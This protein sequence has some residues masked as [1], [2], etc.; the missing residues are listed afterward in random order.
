VYE[1]FPAHDVLSSLLILRNT[2]KNRGGR[3][4]P[5]FCVVVSVCAVTHFVSRAHFCGRAGRQNDPRNVRSLSREG[6]TSC[7]TVRVQFFL[8]TATTA[9][10]L[11]ITAAGAGAQESFADI[12]HLLRPG[13]TVFVTDDTGTETR[14]RV[15]D[16]GPSSL[17]V[18]INGTERDWPAPTVQR[19]E[20]RGDSVRN[21]AIAGSVTAGIFGLLGFVAA[22]GAG[23][24][25]EAFPIVPTEQQ[26]I[27][28]LALL[29]GAGAGIGA[30]IDALIPG[31]TLVYLKPSSRANLE[32]W[33]T[34]N[35]QGLRLQIT[36]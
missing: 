12:Q 13:T 6:S 30:G 24:G 1:R 20:R 29:I 31:R 25:G 19:L 14:G 8:R 27:T 11:L 34:P 28:G 10:F 26:M 7:N 15:V 18:A 33:I 17:R 2:E 3:L 32:P 16:V 21:G 36:F 9:A 22:A 4:M 5:R 23:G 35:A